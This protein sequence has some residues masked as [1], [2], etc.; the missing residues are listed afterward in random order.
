MITDTHVNNKTYRFCN[1]F[2]VYERY[3]LSVCVRINLYPR[4]LSETP[5]RVLFWKCSSEVS[6]CLCG[7]DAVASPGET[8]SHRKPQ[9]ANCTLNSLWKDGSNTKP[10]REYMNSM[11]CV[12]SVILFELWSDFSHFRWSYCINVI[13]YSTLYVRMLLSFLQLWKTD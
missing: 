6:L 8:S 10:I 2:T 5:M 1:R 7:L 11:W 9:F 4:S 13:T 12:G 3:V